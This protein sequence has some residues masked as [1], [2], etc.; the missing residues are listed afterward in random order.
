MAIKDIT[1]LYKKIFIEHGEENQIIVA[2]EEMT[3]LQKE[4][5]KYLRTDA[6]A[7]MYRMSEEIAHVEICMEQLKYVFDIAHMVDDAKRK[8]LGKMDRLFDKK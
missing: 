4:L 1:E 5:C 6:E 8:K 7:T 2:I 3:E